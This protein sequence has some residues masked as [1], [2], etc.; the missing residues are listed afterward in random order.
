MGGTSKHI[1]MYVC[2]HLYVYR[3]RWCGARGTATRTKPWTLTGMP[4]Y[5]YVCVYV[6]QVYIHITF[7]IDLNY[8]YMY[9]YV[10]VYTH[11]YRYVYM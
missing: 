8:T 2:I 3:K 11:I 5:I 7:F 9:T 1:F 4:I 6:G 10:S